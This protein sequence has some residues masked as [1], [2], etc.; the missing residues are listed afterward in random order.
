MKTRKG[1]LLKLKEMIFGTS[2]LWSTLGI[3]A[4]K[5]VYEVGNS[6]E[7]S[8]VMAPLLWFVRNVPQSHVVIRKDGIIEKP[9]P[10]TDLIKRPNKYYGRRNLMGAT[11]LSLLADGNAYWVKVRNGQYKPVELYYVPHWM[12]AP[13]G[14]DSEL[15]SY[16]EYSVN[17]QA[18]PIDRDDVVHFRYGIDPEDTKKG[19]SPLKAIMREIFTDDESANYVAS[20]LVNQGIVG[21]VISPANETAPIQDVQEVR[22]Y[23]DTQYTGTNRGKPLVFSGPTKVEKISFSPSD[24]DLGKIRNVSEERVTAVLGVP[25]AVVGFGTGVQQT[26][27]GAT[28]REL[29]EMAWENGVIP[30][31]GLMAEDLEIQLLPDFETDLSRYE[32]TW[33]NSEVR[34]LKDD[35]GALYERYSR[36]IVNGWLTVGEARERLGWEVDESHNI[37]LRPI[38]LIEVPAHVRSGKT[39]FIRGVKRLWASDRIKT[40]YINDELEVALYRA[41]LKLSNKFEKELKKRFEKYGEIVAETWLEVVKERGMKSGRGKYNGIDPDDAVAIQMVIDRSGEKIAKEEVLGFVPHYLNVAAVTVE[42]VN[43]VMK[44]GINLT[45][46]AENAI[47]DIGGKRMGLIDLPGQTKAKMFDI[48][49]RARAG[50]KGAYEIADMIKEEIPAGPWSSPEIRA[51]VISRTE[52]KFAQNYSSVEVYRDSP[53]ITALQVVDGQLPTSD[54]DC[55][56]RDGMIINFD[57]AKDLMSIEHPNGTMSFLPVVGGAE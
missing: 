49:S 25:A 33:D 20:I 5:Y 6:F 23:I 17:G 43:S 21:V 7:S 28:M 16:Y 37:F 42:T 38:N 26:K 34:A 15:I 36:G 56:A 35:E 12:M 4:N 19:F 50:G 53:D 44:L 29:K 48:I 46:R 55:I 27:V 24:L 14:T 2:P 18:H 40:G 39:A 13:K 47:I 45:D 9:H 1:I 57:E 52:T 54:E 32:V 31:Q 51:K 41:Y 11:V 22:D 8:I 3:R 10:L 30:L